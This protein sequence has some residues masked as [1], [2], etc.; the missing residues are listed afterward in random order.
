MESPIIHESGLQGITDQIVARYAESIDCEPWNRLSREQRIDSTPALLLSMLRLVV[1]DPPEPDLPSRI[2]DCAGKHG[3]VRA[4]QG[5]RD[6]DAILGEYY[7]LRADATKVLA[8]SM[9]PKQWEPV[10]I[11]LD[12]VISVAMMASLR[13]LHGFPVGDMVDQ[14]QFKRG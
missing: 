5:I 6:A 9:D 3:E 1:L 4:L 10:I 13:A 7:L 2:L 11:K 8:Q 14:L 12:R